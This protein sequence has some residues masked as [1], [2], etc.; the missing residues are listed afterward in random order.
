MFG[1]PNYD[2]ASGFGSLIDKHMRLEAETS[3]K[4]VLVGGLK[5]PRWGVDSGLLE[6]TLK[7][8]CRQYGFWLHGRTA[9]HA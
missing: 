2:S 6:K 5:C 1:P 9:I 8:P 3:P 7:D 4:V